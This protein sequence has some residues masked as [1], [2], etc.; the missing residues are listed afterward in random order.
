MTDEPPMPPGARVVVPL[1]EQIIAEEGEMIDTYVFTRRILTGG[2][3]G[4]R[5]RY[6]KRTFENSVPH[7]VIHL[8][9]EVVEVVDVLVVDVVVEVVDVVVVVVVVDVVDVVEVVVEVL[10]VDVD[11]VLVVEVVVVVVV[12]LCATNM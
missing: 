5:R 9:V 11:D 3:G 2:R 8:L 6:K 7:L 12:V 4:C 1:A 10:V